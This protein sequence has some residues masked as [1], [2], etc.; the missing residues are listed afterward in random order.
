MDHPSTEALNRS[1][2]DQNENDVVVN[3]INA[4]LYDE[5]DPGEPKRRSAPS[6]AAAAMMESIHARHSVQPVNLSLKNV[7]YAPVTK[8]YRFKKVKESRQVILNNVSVEIQPFQLSAWMGPS[9]A[10]KSS[11]LKLAAG[12]IKNVKHDLL[13]GSTILINGSKGEIPKNLVSVVWQDDLLLSN[14]TVYETVEFSARLKTDSTV[15]DAEVAQLVQ[16]TITE[17]KLKDVMHSVIGGQGSGGI[18]GGERKRVAVAVEMV[19]RPSVLLLDEPTSGL[20]ST[21]AENLMKLMKNISPF[22]NSIVYLFIESCS[23]IF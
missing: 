19:A 5:T 23:Y 12:L 18:S 21:S 9:G 4:E 13:P 8:S 6:H 2:Y 20:D 15:S 7:T 3:N 10:G 11:L 14:L 17:L 16:E 1:V 22:G